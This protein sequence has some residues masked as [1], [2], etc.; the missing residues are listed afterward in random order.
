MLLNFK[1]E[2]IDII[3]LTCRILKYD[4][5]RTNGIYKIAQIPLNAIPLCPF[6]I[7]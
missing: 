5:F 1:I 7:L 6:K 3:K 4:L 2:L